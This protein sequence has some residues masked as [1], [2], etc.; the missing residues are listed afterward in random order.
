MKISPEKA[1]GLA[2]A[3]GKLVKARVLEP[4]TAIAIALLAVGAAAAF[5]A[6]AP[7]LDYVTTAGLI[8]GVLMP[9][10]HGK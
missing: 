10:G 7:I 8:A 9:E 5:P 1:R 3:I 4:S 6:A 2:G